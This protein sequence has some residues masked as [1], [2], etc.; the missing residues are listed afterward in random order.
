MSIL[1][2]LPL[3][4]GFSWS[5]RFSIW[6]FCRCC[7]TGEHKRFTNAGTLYFIFFCIT[8]E[9]HKLVLPTLK[10]GR[11]LSLPT[12]YESVH[13]FLK[14]KAYRVIDR[15]CWYAVGK[16]FGI[17]IWNWCLY[18]LKPRAQY[19]SRRGDSQRYY[20]KEGVLRGCVVEWSARTMEVEKGT[21]WE[22]SSVIWLRRVWTRFMR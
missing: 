6:C 18:N 17:D 2:P 3:L 4:F 19:M 14:Q 10:Q 12:F 13:H 11:H 1:P 8:V 16:R 15:H 9:N 7:N 22:N 5:A 20:G 21:R